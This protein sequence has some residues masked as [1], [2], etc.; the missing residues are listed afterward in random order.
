MDA[1]AGDAPLEV[2]CLC[3]AWCGVCREWTPAFA[4]L[5]ATF[6]QVRFGWVDVEDE[7]DAM[8]D[9]DIETFP[10]LLIAQGDR[11][12]FLGPVQPSLTQVGRLIESLLA[13]PS[14]TRDAGPEA[15]A[16]LHRFQ[17]AMLPKR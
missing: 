12:R 1:A 10:T 13:S 17:A 2:T 4:Q 15:T 3:A 11:A 16:L 8:G 6:P 7:A 5:A 9:L 14:G